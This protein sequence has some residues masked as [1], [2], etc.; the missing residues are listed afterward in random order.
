MSCSVLEKVI[1]YCFLEK[2]LSMSKIVKAMNALLI[3]FDLTIH[4][5]FHFILEI[6]Q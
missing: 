4:R 1:E 3:S 6:N 2:G 5:I